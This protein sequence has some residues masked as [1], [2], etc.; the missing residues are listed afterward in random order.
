MIRINNVGTMKP[1]RLFDLSR[2]AMEY[3]GGIERGLISSLKV[4]ILPLGRRYKPGPLTG[5]VEEIVEEIV[6]KEARPR[7][8]SEARAEAT[9]GIALPLI[10]FLTTV[11]EPLTDEAARSGDAPAAERA[12]CREQKCPPH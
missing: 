1:G 2:A 5:E 10:P 11:G 9:P 4:T 3:F 8:G 7:G 6:V 12:K